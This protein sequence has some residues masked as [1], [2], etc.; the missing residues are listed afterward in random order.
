MVVVSCVFLLV[1]LLLQLQ[2]WVDSLWQVGCGPFDTT[3]CDCAGNWL[4]E[5]DRST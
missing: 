3:G 1:V 5:T 4:L 2:R